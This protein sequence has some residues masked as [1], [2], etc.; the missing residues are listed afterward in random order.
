MF[1]EAFNS[2]R[3]LTI[4][5]HQVFEGTLCGRQGAFAWH[6]RAS[7]RGDT[8]KASCEIVEGSGT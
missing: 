1:G 3:V 8:V 2:K 5:G 6:E 7:K 4:E